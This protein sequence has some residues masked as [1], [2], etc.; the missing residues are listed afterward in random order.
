M[1]KPEYDV[2]FYPFT[3]RACVM[4][5]TLKAGI[6]LYNFQQIEILHKGLGFADAC[7]KAREI[8]ELGIKPL[9]R[10]IETV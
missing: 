9:V 2:W 8:N 1:S 4:H 3:G 7:K 6:G 10:G 5:E